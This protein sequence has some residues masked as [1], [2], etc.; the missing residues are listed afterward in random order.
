MFT[1]PPRPPKDY[2]IKNVTNSLQSSAQFTPDSLPRVTQPNLAKFCYPV[3]YED[4]EVPELKFTEIEPSIFNRMTNE[5]KA[6]WLPAPGKDDF[7]LHDVYKKYSK[8]PQNYDAR[9]RNGG[10]T[11]ANIFLKTTLFKIF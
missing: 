11:V 10:K 2:V 4:D 3:E 6:L 9:F 8:P 1:L 7:L 5:A